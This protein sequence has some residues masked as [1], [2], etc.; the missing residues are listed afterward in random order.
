MGLS[1]DHFRAVMSR[2]T[3][4]ITVI[5]ARHGEQVHGM[6]ASSFCSVSTDPMTVLFCADHRTRT[7]PLVQASGAFAVSILSEDQEDTFRVFAGWKGERD[8]KFAGE[9]TF[10]AVTGT[11]ILK[12]SLGWLDCRVL[13]AY[14]GG[15][16]HTI[17]VGEVLAADAGAGAGRPPLVYYHRKV[18]PITV[19]DS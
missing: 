14:P 6:V 7:Y 3:T 5:T 18:R 19:D 15:N 1:I 17:F 4:G 8:D 12:R 13:A 10:T 16:T 11:P 2:W 9:E